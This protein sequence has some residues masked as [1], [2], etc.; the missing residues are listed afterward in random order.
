MGTKLTR[1][2]KPKSPG[3]P[4]TKWCPKCREWRLFSA[5]H[6]NKAQSDGL[7]AHCRVHSLQ[8]KVIQRHKLQQQ[9]RA[10][11]EEENQA[12]EDTSQPF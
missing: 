4:D 12:Q 6:K 9:V 3:P 5:F 7:S 11:R 2:T 8:F 1:I 10:Q